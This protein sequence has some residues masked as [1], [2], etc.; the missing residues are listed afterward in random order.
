MAHV[1]K[2]EYWIPASR[3]IFPPLVGGN[4]REGGTIN[5]FHP[6]LTPPLKGG[7]VRRNETDVP[8]IKC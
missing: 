7:A 3:V 5:N 2:I 1:K 8:M 6:P 4:K